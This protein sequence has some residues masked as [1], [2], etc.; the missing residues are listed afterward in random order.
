MGKKGSIFIL[1]TLVSWHAFSQTANVQGKILD[2]KKKT[3]LLGVYVKLANQLDT[4]EYYFSLTDDEGEFRFIGIKFNTYILT[5]TLIG[6]TELT[7]TVRVAKPSV[8]LGD[9]WMEEAVISLQG[10]TVHG[11]PP[12]AI[13]KTD[14]TEFNAGAFKTNP[15]AD[16]ED[17]VSKLPGITVQ[18]GTVTSNGEQVQQVLVDGKPFFGND[19]TLALR[20]LPA[21]AIAKIQVFDKLSDQAEFTG[22]DDGQS[23]K[24]INFITRRDRR[25]QKFGKSYGGYGDDDRYNAGGGINFFHGPTR[26]SA[27]GLA[28]NVNQQN[29]STQ[30]L[31]DVTGSN[32]RGGLGGYFGGRGGGGGGRGGYGGGGYQGGQFSGIGNNVG[33]F[34]IGQQS[35]ISNTNSIG[36]NYND[37]YG[38]D[39]S[40]SQSYFFNTAQNTND[41]KIHR[42]YLATTDTTSLYDENDAAD[43]RNFNHRYD[44]RTEYRM[45][46]ANSFIFQPHL[47]FQANNTSSALAGENYLSP[48]EVLNQAS[49]NNDATTT[50]NN[51]SGHILYRHRFD[52]PGRT[53]S[54]DV[55]M[56]SNFKNGSTDLLSSAEYYTDPTSSEILDQQGTI[57][58]TGSSVSPRMVY[59][60]PL[61]V[62]SMLQVTYNPSFSMNKS[63][64]RTYNFDSTQQ[65]YS[66]LD[67]AL[68]NT[69]NN[70]Y[71]TQ[72]GSVGYRFRSSQLNF[73]AD[74]AYQQAMLRGEQEFPF[75][76]NISRTFYDFLPS[77]MLNYR[78]DRQSNLRIFY[79]SS[80]LAPTISQLQNVINN[81]NPLLLAT[82][83]PDLK[84]S[85][86]NTFLSRYAWTDPG[87]GESFFWFFTVAN[88]KDYIANSSITATRDS[89]L[90][91]GVTLNPG[92]QLTLPVNLDGYWN[93]R[94]FTTYSIPARFLKSNVNLTSG[95]SFTRTPGLINNDLNIENLSALS[96]GAVL[97]SNISEDVDFTLSYTGNYN[98]SRNTI[99]PSQ[100]DNYYNHTASVKLNL[101]F[102][103]GFVLR[104]DANNSL[105]SGLSGGYNQNYTVWNANVGK[106][107]LTK[108]SG[109]L[110][111][112]VTD[113]LNENKS[114]NRTVTDTYIEDTQ[115]TVLGRYYMLMFTYTLR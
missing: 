70:T 30:D 55:D 60:E 112:L 12:P 56:S 83:N 25:N 89:V 93:V 9:L 8:D 73:M 52:L 94:S 80:T 2:S 21:D 67:Q 115:S 44:M 97:A 92:S 102:W 5:A 47:Y 109:E 59:T 68:S 17:L 32:Q 103:K 46:S 64:N 62:N 6:H 110:T 76:T 13:Q 100:N 86:S 87:K 19:P 18:N 14:T 48:D 27:I 33:S 111:F 42:N 50:G 4:N 43:S 78:S 95:I 71:V 77:M 38:S 54:M 16:A 82:G 58:T 49:E 65:S 20:S 39:V 66:D 90:T 104:T 91:G 40:T 106:K 61:E 29:F 98:I 75:S 96:A 85:Y 99:D 72:K 51:L 37:D 31:L 41:Q 28:D 79:R 81:T 22:F 63:D 3:S 23:I 107:F 11:E 15:D 84:Q 57:L 45:D 34:L 53:F 105:Y 74:F 101:I 10:L 36:L 69:F 24:T 114:I 113:L 35:G 1:L 88:T 7:K 26:V 108:D